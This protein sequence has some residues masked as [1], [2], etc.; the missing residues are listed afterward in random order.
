MKKLFILM[1]LMATLGAWAQNADERSVVRLE[2]DSGVVRIALYNET[3]IHRDNFLKLVGE[4]FYD[5]VL[6]HRVINRFM[7]QT[8]DSLSR[9]AAPG[10]ELGDGF[11]ETYQLPAEFRFPQLFHKRGTVA[12]AREGDN[13]NPERQSSMCQFYIVTGHRYSSN[14]LD[15]VEERVS[16]ATKDIFRFPPEVRD[17]YQQVGG[18]PHLDTQYT[19]FGEVIE[20]MDI[21][22]RIQKAATDDNDRPIADIHI[23]RAV[24]E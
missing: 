24:K 17:A 15:D 8:G 10:Q 14:A 11:Y 22:D 3:P 1:M 4:G 13:V 7:V 18:T 19:V 20:G 5:G 2:T 16:Q 21:V 6:F 23:L 9:H 12:A